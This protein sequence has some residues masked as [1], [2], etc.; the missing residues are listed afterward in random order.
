MC[1]MSPIRHSANIDLYER[2]RVGG[3]NFESG[4]RTKMLH[5]S[6]SAVSMGEQP[7][8]GPSYA[9]RSSLVQPAARADYS[10]KSYAS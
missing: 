5:N 3:E 4:A 6:T 9:C 2:E 10:K 1:E 8:R 7:T